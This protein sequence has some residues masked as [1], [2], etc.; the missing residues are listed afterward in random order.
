[1]NQNSWSKIHSLSCPTVIEVQFPQKSPLLL[2]DQLLQGEKTQNINCFYPPIF[3][4][5]CLTSA[6][7]CIGKDFFSSF[8][9][10]CHFCKNPKAHPLVL[11]H[12]SEVQPP[13]WVLLF[14]SLL[15]SSLQTS[16]SVVLTPLKVKELLQKWHLSF[17]LTG[18][19]LKN[20]WC[21]DK[22]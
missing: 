17:G 10:I 21:P 7:P 3:V 16:C 5:W 20:F 18:F 6:A 22:W 14:L 15:A 13:A 1:M 9:P 2:Y 12:L 8:H 19:Y 4:Q 11:P